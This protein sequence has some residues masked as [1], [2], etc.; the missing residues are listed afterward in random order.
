MMNIL[1]EIFKKKFLVLLQIKFG[2]IFVVNL[3]IHTFVSWL[4]TH[5]MSLKKKENGHKGI[6]QERFLDLVHVRDTLSLTLKTNMCRQLLH[7]QFGVSK[8]HDQ[9]Y[10]G[11]RNR[12]DYMYLFLS[13]TINVV[14]ASSKCHDELQKAKATEIEHLL[15]LSEIESGKGL[16]QVRT[17]RRVGDTRWGSHFHFV[18]SLLNMFDCTHVVLQGII[19]NVPKIHSKYIQMQDAMQPKWTMPGRDK[20]YQL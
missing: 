13:F 14:C 3:G 10:D 11:A 19:C 18:C 20:S 17:L 16:N 6:I 2:S 8:I 4:M 1:M 5:E 9:G 12:M 7:N 15:E